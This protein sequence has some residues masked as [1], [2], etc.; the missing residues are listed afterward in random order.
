MEN[1]IVSSFK[2]LEEKKSSELLFIYKEQMETETEERAWILTELAF[3]KRE[4]ISESENIALSE[5]RVNITKNT[6]F[7]IKNVPLKT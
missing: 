2:D 4:K 7:L 3:F 1:L 5:N 6:C